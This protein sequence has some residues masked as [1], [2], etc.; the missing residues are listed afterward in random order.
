MITM[1]SWK[2]VILA[3]VATAALMFT[4]ACGGGSSSSS[5]GGGSSSGGSSSDSNSGD[6]GSQEVLKIDI[7][8]VYAEDSAPSKGVV[9]FKELVEERSEGSIEINFFPNGSLGT[10]R[11]NFEAVSSG[12]L[13]GVLGGWQG[14]DMYAPEYM[15]FSA[16]FLFN[17]MDHMLAV[18]ESDL[19]KDMF[20]KMDEA[21]VHH[22]GTIIRGARNMTSNE[23]FTTPEEVQGL[24]LRLPEIEAWV[25]SWNAIGASPTPI[26][27]PEL[28][29]A[30]QTGV[31][32]ASEGP[33]EQFYTF[34][35]QEVQ[36][37]IINTG[38]VYETTFVWLNNDLWKSLT[39]EQRD[40]IQ[41]ASD[42]AMEYANET[43]VSDN[44]EF[45]KLMKEDGMEVLEADV[46]AFVKA[47]QPGLEKFFEEKW[48]VTDIDEINSFDK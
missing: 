25:A 47:A 32:E 42:E 28:Y 11:E 5:S 38:H 43:A 45:L 29:G 7:A 3:G 35:L 21:N 37:Y 26:A 36:D 41:T 48:T 1:K 4:A 44:K 15:F 40:I 14:Q 8:S 16:P 20:A 12:D 30:L 23:A 10:E 34:K 46:P 33:Y 6:S 39:D 19:G 2:K 18:L 17:S 9:K 31:V 24:K 22:I 27:L 13:Q